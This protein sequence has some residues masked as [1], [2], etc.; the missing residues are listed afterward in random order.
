LIIYLTL[1]GKK[2]SDQ[3]ISCPNDDSDLF[4]KPEK[5][6]P[7]IKKRLKNYA[8]ETFII[9]W[10]NNCLDSINDKFTLKNTIEQYKKLLIDLTQSKEIEERKELVEYLGKE[11][12]MQQAHYLVD[13]WN[14]VKWHVEMDFWDELKNTLPEQLKNCNFNKDYNYAVENINKSAHSSRRGNLDYGLALNLFE[15]DEGHVLF[16][17]YRG[18]DS[19]SYGIRIYNKEISSESTI[20]K[21]IGLIKYLKKLF[22]EFIMGEN[23]S[24]WIQWKHIQP[25]IDFESFNNPTTLSLANPEKRKKIITDLWEEMTPYINK[26]LEW[27]KSNNK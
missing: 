7:L 21:P 10:L 6:N 23:V 18:S 25:Y 11:N 9:S 20:P 26:V 5:I 22:P 14:H 16:M 2:P 17:V 27:H 3:S 24:D 13:N 15:V 8:Y 4:S 19:L 1:N 12:L